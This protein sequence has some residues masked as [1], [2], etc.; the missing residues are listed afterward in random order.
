MACAVVL[1][2]RL[3]AEADDDDGMSAIVDILDGS[4]RMQLMATLVAVRI[5]ELVC[6]ANASLTASALVSS[7]S[8]PF[9]VL[10]RLLRAADTAGLLRFLLTLPTTRAFS[11]FLGEN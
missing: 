8:L 10:H 4:A 2:T 3:P 5:P 1:A 6:C 9:D 7:A 11:C